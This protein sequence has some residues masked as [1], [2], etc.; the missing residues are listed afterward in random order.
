MGGM[1]KSQAKL[2]GKG[3]EFRGPLP[4]APGCGKI[5]DFWPFQPFAKALAL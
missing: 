4:I 1:T 2:W 5:P 3:G